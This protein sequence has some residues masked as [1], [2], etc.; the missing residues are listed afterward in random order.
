MG[1]FDSRLYQR[2]NNNNSNNFPCYKIGHRHTSSRASFRLLSINSYVSLCALIPSQS[3]TTR[4]E[5]ALWF[6]RCNVG[7]IC[8]PQGRDEGRKFN[9]HW[10][11]IFRPQFERREWM[12][13]R[14]LSECEYARCK[15]AFGGYRYDWRLYEIQFARN[16]VAFDTLAC[17]DWSFE[18]S[19][20]LLRKLNGLS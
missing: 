13:A 8:S 5:C 19:N 4:S 1:K 18:G 7:C 15:S 12:P 14:Y 17:L 16:Y 9:L 2:G 11:M 10:I 6:P 20:R 3:T